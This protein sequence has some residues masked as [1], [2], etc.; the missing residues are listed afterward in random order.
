MLTVESCG[1]AYC[2]LLIPYTGWGGLQRAS[3]WKTCQTF[4]LDSLLPRE[5]T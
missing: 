5:G 2:I 1:L 3:E 4:S